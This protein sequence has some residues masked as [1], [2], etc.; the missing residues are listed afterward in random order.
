MFSSCS[1]QA[2][3]VIELQGELALLLCQLSFF[4]SV[5][6]PF[7]LS[8]DQHAEGKGGGAVRLP[9]GP[10]CIVFCMAMSLCFMMAVHIGSSCVC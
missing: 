8:N 9:L 10:H 3:N 2:L 4:H 5:S 1:I 6:L 7:C